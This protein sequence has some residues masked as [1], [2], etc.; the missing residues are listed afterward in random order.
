[1]LSLYFVSHSY[2]YMFVYRFDKAPT[3][4]LVSSSRLF[5]IMGSVIRHLP[6]RY[7]LTGERVSK[8]I[9]LHHMETLLVNF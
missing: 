4:E 9:A 8:I 7:D 2:S 6:F 3:V 5:G 1:M